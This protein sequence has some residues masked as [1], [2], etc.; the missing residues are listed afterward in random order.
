[1]NNQTYT[2]QEI[3]EAF[4]EASRNNYGFTLEKLIEKLK[5]LK[6]KNVQNKFKEHPHQTG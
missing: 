1:M 2:E 5:E 4:L 3:K 6:E